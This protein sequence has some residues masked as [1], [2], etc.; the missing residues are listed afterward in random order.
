VS[1]RATSRSTEWCRR[2]SIYSHYC[3]CYYCYCCCCCYCCCNSTSLFV[4]HSI[5]HYTGATVR[6]LTN[7]MRHL[8]LPTC[9]LRPYLIAINTL[10]FRVEL[11]NQSKPNKPNQTNK[12]ERERAQASTLGALRAEPQK[13]GV[14][15]ERPREQRRHER[16]RKVARHHGHQRERQHRQAQQCHARATDAP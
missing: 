12:R 13:V 4:L 3:C 5:V 7:S 11:Y 6:T 14:V 1:E 8:H 9:T 16:E 2:P 15:R 10:R